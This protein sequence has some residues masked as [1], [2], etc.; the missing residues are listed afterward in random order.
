L[1]FLAQALLAQ[2]PEFDA[3]SIKPAPPPDGRD[4]RVG[5]RGGPGTKDPGMFTCE[6][7]Q[8]SAIISR[9]YDLKSYQ[10]SSKDPMTEPRFMIAAKVPEGA[11]KPQFREM[12]QNMLKDRF[13]LAFHH[14]KKEMTAYDLLLTKNGPKFKESSAVPDG[15][16]SPANFE[17]KDA[18]GF[19]ILPAGRRSVMMAIMGGYS[20]QR[21]GDAPIEELADMLAA[22]MHGPVIDGTGLKGKYDFTLRWIQEG[23]TATNETPG[24]R[25]LEAIQ[26]QLGLRLQKTKR[27]VD[28]FV[29]DHM[30]EMPTEN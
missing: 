28:I 16:L 24:P 20:T 1:L 13:K 21:F 14:E 29:V 5:S 25:L 27:V 23:G 17:K 11:T 30:E 15:D 10:F 8:I 22:R 18:D 2:L 7:C 26:D 4:M 12:L 3:V 19:P 6:N 9:A